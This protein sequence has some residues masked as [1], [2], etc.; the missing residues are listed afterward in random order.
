MQPGSL[1]AP[2]E[3]TTTDAAVHRKRDEQMKTKS[4]RKNLRRRL[5]F[6][7]LRDIARKMAALNSD[8]FTSFL[9]PGEARGLCHV[10]GVVRDGK[11][12]VG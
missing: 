3:A 9:R 2:E 1:G 8:I 10:C 4:K 5:N 11:L 6:A 7:G 12:G